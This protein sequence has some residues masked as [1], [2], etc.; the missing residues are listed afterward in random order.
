MHYNI[1]LF[2]A[3]LTNVLSGKGY[4]TLVITTTLKMCGSL[5]SSPATWVLSILIYIYSSPS[6]YMNQLLRPAVVS[7]FNAMIDLGNR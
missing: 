3:N 1:A 6:K 4:D 7:D 2:S 5:P